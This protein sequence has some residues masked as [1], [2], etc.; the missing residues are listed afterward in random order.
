MH[1]ENACKDQSLKSNFIFDIE[2]IDQVA[3]VAVLPCL[4]AEGDTASTLHLGLARVASLRLRHALPLLV[5]LGLL[6]V[7]QA[8]LTRH[9]PILDPLLRY[10]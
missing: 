2:Q 9:G 6:E 8:E 10:L 4:D 5:R 3:V 1:D 7:E